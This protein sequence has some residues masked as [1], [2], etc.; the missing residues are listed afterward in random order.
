MSLIRGQQQ[1]LCIALALANKPKFILV[2]P[3]SALDPQ[4]TAKIE[5][6]CLV[7]LKK[8]EHLDGCYI[9][10]AKQEEF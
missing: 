6:L 1:R 10:V 3:T 5:D 9:I 4:S 7:L 2:E 8:R